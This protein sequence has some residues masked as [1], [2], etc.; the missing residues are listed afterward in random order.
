MARLRDTLLSGGFQEICPG[1]EPPVGSHRGALPKLTGLRVG[2]VV[3]RG[4]GVVW[5]Q[6]QAGVLHPGKVL[7]PIC[8]AAPAR[9]EGTAVERGWGRG[10]THKVSTADTENRS[11]PGPAQRRHAPQ[12]PSSA[13]SLQSLVPSHTRSLAR[14]PPAP[15]RNSSGPQGWEAEE[16]GGGKVGGDRSSCR[17]E[18][19]SVPQKKPCAQLGPE[20]ARASHEGE[21]HCPSNHLHGRSAPTMRPSLPPCST[22]ERDSREEGGAHGRSR[23]SGTPRRRAPAAPSRR[24]PGSRQR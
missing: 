18:T 10:E 17:T 23:S 11:W 13:P 19:T 6:L 7:E 24:R 21:S 5:G 20:P 12:S 14:H 4:P 16:R 1:A 9:L 8:P 15:Q 22:R 3:P 2:A